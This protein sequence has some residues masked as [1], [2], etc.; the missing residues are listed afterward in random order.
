[1]TSA[2]S[3]EKMS[4]KPKKNRPL[5]IIVLSAVVLLAAAI[6]EELGGVPRMLAGLVR[7][8][9]AVFSSGVGR[10]DHRGLAAGLLF[11]EASTYS[12]T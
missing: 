2:T 5:G 10:T 8:R 9:L 4:E 6:L 1:M 3:S 12:D 7:T 11:P